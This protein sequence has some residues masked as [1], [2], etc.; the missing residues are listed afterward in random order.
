[1]LLYELAVVVKKFYEPAEGGWLLAVLLLDVPKD[2]LEVHPCTMAIEGIRADLEVV[3]HVDA[4]L[5]L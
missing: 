4:V 3:P 5:L 2:Y 1:M